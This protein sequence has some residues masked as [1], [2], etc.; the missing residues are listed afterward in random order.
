MGRE[1]KFLLALLG[2]LAGVFVGVVSLKLFVPRPPDGVGPDV[3]TDV[4]EAQDLVE[5]PA[6]DPPPI[7][8][9]PPRDDPYAGR[10]SRFS[11]DGP[12]DPAP[13]DPFV[14]PASFDA[15]LPR[16]LAAEED[17]LPPPPPAASE[18]LPLDSPAAAEPASA[19]TTPPIR[20]APLSDPP[21]VLASPPEQPLPEPTPVVDTPSAPSAASALGPVPGDAYVT[22]P[23]DTWWSIAERAYGDGR[24]YRGLFAWNRAV[25]PRVTLAAGTRLEIPPVAR[26]AA[27]WPT[28][29]PR[30]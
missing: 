13:R 30:D 14:V 4:A 27:A 3:H 21:P 18:P 24:L 8:G 10:S 19:A 16:P 23:G 20:T 29:V 6:L 12:A 11:G 26:L 28:L 5:P 7:R 9:E 17:L 1:T 25:D 2:L 15:D 22:R